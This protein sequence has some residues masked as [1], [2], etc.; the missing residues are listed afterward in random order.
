MYLHNSRYITTHETI[1]L[2]DRRRLRLFT[3]DTNDT[4]ALHT[5]SVPTLFLLM[6]PIHFPSI[7]CLHRMFTFFLLFYFTSCLLSL[8]LLLSCLLV[9]IRRYPC[10]NDANRLILRL[11]HDKLEPILATLVSF[12][13][14]SVCLFSY[15]FLRLTV[16]SSVYPCSYVSC[17]LLVQDI[18]CRF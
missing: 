16:K 15:Y 12:C 8:S 1:L 9:A 14:T 4:S 5:C 13:H 3:Y 11:L 17:C 2:Y 7:L 18:T 10:R 6:I